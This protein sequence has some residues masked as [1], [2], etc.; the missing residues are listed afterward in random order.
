M[1][2]IVPYLCGSI[3]FDLLLQAR[4]GRGKVR[5]RQYG[6]TDGL[7]DQDI[8]KGLIYVVTGEKIEIKGD[9]FAKATSQYKT[10]EINGNTY[11]PFNDTATINA[12]DDEYINKRYDIALRMT[13][14]AERYLNGKKKEWLVK[15]I[16]ET[17]Q[18]D[19]TIPD[20]VEFILDNSHRST[21]K[22]LSGSLFIDINIFL[23]SVLHYILTERPDNE[24]G[25]ATFKKW[26][27]RES[28][29]TEWKFNSDIGANSDSA[30]FFIPIQYFTSSEDF[31]ESDS[32]ADKKDLNNL[33]LN[34][35]GEVINFVKPGEISFQKYLDKTKKYYS[36]IKTLLYSENPQ[37]FYDFYVCNTLDAEH[38]FMFMSNVTHNDK[39]EKFENIDISKLES[40]S[41][42]III[43]GTGG[44]GK[45]MMMRHLL[46]DSINNYDKLQKIPVLISL[47]NYDGSCNLKTLICNTIQALD[48]SITLYDIYDLLEN[49]EFRNIFQ[50]N[51]IF[52]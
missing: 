41:N 19:E 16:L 48:S 34:S 46:L 44:I 40:I 7:S 35:S 29:Y 5:D 32:T 33:H 24:K 27:I 8:M 47:K 9:T 18:T 37:P 11:I 15:A 13:N 6:G 25:K 36:K 10:C 42:Y 23:S 22:Y 1:P 2:N 38:R 3:F 12:F 14:F 17:I 31:I 28:P 51:H 52:K 49:G 21:K 20:D 45:S 26:F 30:V 4:K 39:I 50:M 43:S